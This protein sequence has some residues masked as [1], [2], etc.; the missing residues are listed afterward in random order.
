MEL[1]LY[2]YKAIDEE[3]ECEV[4]RVMEGEEKDKLIVGR[5]QEVTE[6]VKRVKGTIKHRF[7]ALCFWC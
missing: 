4:A 6:S 3:A 2:R 5:D 1:G 7:L